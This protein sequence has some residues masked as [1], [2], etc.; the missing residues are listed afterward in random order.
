MIF[1]SQFFDPAVPCYFNG[2]IS[3]TLTLVGTKKSYTFTTNSSGT[4]GVKYVIPDTYS[5]TGGISNY[6][7]SITVSATGGTY[8]IYPAGAV[9]WYGREVV[10]MSG[11]GSGETVIA[12]KNVNPNYIELFFQASSTKHAAFYTTTNIMNISAYT[13]CNFVV[14]MA[15]HSETGTSGGSIGTGVAD[16]QGVT[17]SNREDVWWGNV[18]TSETS[19]TTLSMNV[20]SASTGYPGVWDVNYSIAH[21]CCHLHAIWFE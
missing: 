18:W 5:V 19:P 1:N 12:N 17:Y 9:Y 15:T 11:Y 2:A 6:T 14:N 4:T 3:E 20:S 10:P 16:R 7:C 13:T 8:N 21:R